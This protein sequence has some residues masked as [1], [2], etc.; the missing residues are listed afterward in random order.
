MVHSDSGSEDPYNR[1]QG[2]DSDG[3]DE[4]SAASG[5][6]GGGGGG[7]AAAA[8]AGGAATDID[9]ADD[10]QLSPPRRQSKQRARGA[11]GAP[12]AGASGKQPKCKR[13]VMEWE[14]LPG[15]Q[16]IIETSLDAFIEA[17]GRKVAA[18]LLCSLLAPLLRL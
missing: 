10:F 15:G 4:S 3:S 2:A 13:A 14:A 12:A 1:C 17:H 5:A 18:G 6:G 16:A 8:A 7:A 11:G 9:G